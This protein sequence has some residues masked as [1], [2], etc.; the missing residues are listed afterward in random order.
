MLLATGVAVADEA[1]DRA[2][3]ERIRTLTNRSADG[4]SAQMQPNGGVS[5]DLKARFQHAYL[6]QQ[7][8]DGELQ[9]ACVGSIGEANA[10][11]G[12]DLET[13]AAVQQIHAQPQSDLAKRA[14][15]HGMTALQYQRYWNLI[16]Q[17]KSKLAPDAATFSV[18][19]NDG[20][21]EGFNDPSPRL[22]EFG[23]AG[24]TL[25]QQR[26]NVFSRAGLIW[27]GFVDSNVTI[28]VRGNFD[29]L[30]PCGPGGGV[31]GSAGPLNIHRDFPNA[32]FA[33]T[34]YPAP[35]ANKLAGADQNA[36]NPDIG[37]TFNSSVDTGCLGPGTRFY[38]G[39]DN[40]T[41]SGTINLLVVVLHEIAHGMGSLSFTDAANGAFLGNM[42][43]I[44]ARFMLDRNIGQTWLNM[45]APQRVTSA[46]TPNNLFWDGPSVR[47][48]SGLLSA[49]AEAGTGR[50]ELFTPSVLQGGSSVSH[51]GT[52]ASPNLLMEPSINVGL[53]LTLDLTRQQ[54]RDIGWYRD[55]TSDLVRDQITTV[56]PNSGSVT[57]GGNA[58][59]SWTNTG[60]FNRNVTLELSTDGGANFGTVIA[61]DVSNTG[62]F[63]WSVPNISTTQARIRVREH[64]FAE[65]VGVSSANFSIGGGNTAPVFT[66]GAAIARQQG[67]PAGAPVT[68]GT[69]SDAQTA[70]GALAVTQIAG[71]TASGVT[72]S[73][74]TNSNGTVSASLAASCAASSGTVRF[75][76]FDGALTATGD[77][78][79]NVSAN[80]APVL[81]T[82]P[83]R[84]LSLAGSANV[85]PSAAPSDNGSVDQLTASAPGFAGSLSAMLDTGVVQISNAGP[86]NTYVVTVQARDNCNATSQRTFNLTVSNDQLLRNGFESAVR[87]SE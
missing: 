24:T 22:A 42:P 21:G 2:L 47:I 67:S 75:Q 48:G 13:G 18:V 79:V 59:I 62:S 19:N 82:Y 68:V 15:A 80:A 50:V 85:N 35:L 16:E 25:G 63:N 56:T 60:G 31:L 45:T 66:P 23:N 40:A 26:L 30:T 61:S 10:F 72:I 6:A 69:V 11:F 38:Y 84:Q 1:S 70:P 51:W 53:P 7:G 64:D 9:A 20:A 3:A 33:N 83:N 81:G 44:W 55:T 87:S 17:S 39:L 4:L 77:L 37:A 46:I 36:A 27:G 76:V 65:P 54:M 32:P 34:F 29:P 71:G 5:I 86:I 73:G 8:P 28:Q 57:G 58:T 12:R 43:D 49:G 52:V 74:V 78:Q 14:A 41:P